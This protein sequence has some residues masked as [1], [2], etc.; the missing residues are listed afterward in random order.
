VKFYTT[1][2][3]APTEPG[4]VLAALTGALAPFDL[5][6]YRPEPYDPDAAWDWWQLPAREVLP[7]R[8]GF[9]DDP[10]AVRAG[11]AIVVAAPKSIVDFD[12]ARRAAGQYAAGAW[13]AWA[14]V[15]R[16]H[17]GTLPRTHFGVDQSAYLLQPGIQEIARAAATQQHPYFD[18]SLLLGDPVAQFGGDRSEFVAWAAA[19]AVATHAYVTLDGR[20]LSEY[21]DDRGWDVHAVAM[22]DYLDSLPDDTVIACAW[23]H[24]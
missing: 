20:W 7:L 5:N 21:T 4:S 12:A 18:F 24:A 2:F 10:R 8:P 13:D 14:E 15:A 22:T 6:D 11:D 3:L 1:V 9:A 16:A 17:P 19:G 23:C